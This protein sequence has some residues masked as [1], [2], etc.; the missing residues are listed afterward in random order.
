MSREEAK[1][2]AK[3]IRLLFEEYFLEGS[4]IDLGFAKIHPKLHKPRMIKSNLDGRKYFMGESRRWKVDF[5][6]KWLKESN[7][8]WSIE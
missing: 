5:R 3:V 2:T 7:P 6:K 8:F 1:K 4:E